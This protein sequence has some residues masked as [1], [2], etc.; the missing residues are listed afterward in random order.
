MSTNTA[1]ILVQLGINISLLGVL[2]RLRWIDKAIER[3]P[4][5]IKSQT[6]DREQYVEVLERTVRNLGVKR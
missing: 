5:I 3:L 1:I 4:Y 2:L 6:E